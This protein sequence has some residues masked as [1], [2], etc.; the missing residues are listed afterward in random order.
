[1]Y[2]LAVARLDADPGSHDMETGLRL[3]VQLLDTLDRQPTAHLNLALTPRSAGALARLSA[4]TE[5]LGRLE[6]R[7]AVAFV[8]STSMPADPVSGA[9]DAVTGTFGPRSR[10]LLLWPAGLQT[11]PDVVLKAVRAELAGIL[12]READVTPADPTGQS[13]ASLRAHPGLFVHPV[14]EEA[15]GRLLDGTDEAHA[16]LSQARADTG[17]LGVVAVG[18]APVPTHPGGLV[19][20][21]ERGRTLLAEDTPRVIR[22]RRQVSLRGC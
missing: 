21:L 4:M 11:S 18:L 22:G 2:W 1:M 3:L 5:R 20:L 10:P 9:V 13:L 6:D 12:V 15:A 19:L 7:G 16:L 17:R 8:A 14:D